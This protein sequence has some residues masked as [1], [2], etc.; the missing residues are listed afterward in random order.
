MFKNRHVLRKKE[1]RKILDE[2]ENQLDCKIEGEVEI[3]DFKDM[4]ILL[5]NKKFV[6]FFIDER[7]FLN[8]AGF[9]AYSPK[10]KYLTVDDGAIKHIVGGADVMAPGIIEMDEEIKKGDMVW[11]RDARGNPI[12]VGKALMD[13]EEIKKKGKGKAVENIHH[14]GDEIWRL[15][16]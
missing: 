7:L 2:I 5:I 15:S 11:V 1:A 3:A 6:A 9:R 4:K 8:L 12:A 14:L 16:V 10:K 13:A